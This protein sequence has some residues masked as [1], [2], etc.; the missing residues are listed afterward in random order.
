MRWSLPPPWS[1]VTSQS[2]LGLAAFTG[3]WGTYAGFTFDTIYV[4][5]IW[6]G[7][8][9]IV[10]AGYLN[11]AGRLPRIS[12]TLGLFAWLFMSATIVTHAQYV[13]TSTG[14]PMWDGL[15]AATDQALGIDIPVL[16]Q[17]TGSQGWFADLSVATYRSFH[18]QTFLAYA[19]L[20][21]S[22]RFDR[23]RDVIT[24]MTLGLA[25]TLTMSWLVPSI[26][27]AAHY[28]ITDQ[29]LGHL[30]ASGAAFWHVEHY[31]ALH[32]GLMKEFPSYG[33]WHGLVSF[34]SFHVIQTLIAIYAVSYSRP[35]ALLF[36]VWSGLIIFTTIP[37]G[38]H[39]FVDLIGGHLIFAAM[40]LW[41]SRGAVAAPEPAPLPKL[42][43]ADEGFRWSAAAS[44]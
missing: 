32:A 40:V 34:P 30:K 2:L 13:G 27:M 37:V 11:A 10:V 42:T 21:A 33:G 28:N 15:M 16:V 12:A 7:L 14:L 1:N 26:G 8:V 44:H 25:V 19:L 29:N 4:A 38:G 41:L 39:H 23:L 9:L 24:M 43:R 31:R 35:L 22:G 3:L 20:I 5:P 36:S 6:L 17:I 18:Q